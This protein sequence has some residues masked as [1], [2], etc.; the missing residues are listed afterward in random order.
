MT[1]TQ[2]QRLT[3]NYEEY[4]DNFEPD[5]DRE[6]PLEFDEWLQDLM[7]AAADEAYDRKFDP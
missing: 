2:Y 5:E 4:I 1:S 3:Y 6:T 7:D